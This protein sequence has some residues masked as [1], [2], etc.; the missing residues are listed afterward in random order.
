[1]KNKK[2]I[3]ILFPITVIIWSLILIRIIKPFNNDIRNV[4]PNEVVVEGQKLK[5]KELI[6]HNNIRRD[7][8]LWI[9]R[10]IL[11]P[12]SVILTHPQVSIQ[13]TDIN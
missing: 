7:P 2:T 9:F 5:N 13:R 6:V 3:L 11:T 12:A 8:F 10:S 1:M 4:K